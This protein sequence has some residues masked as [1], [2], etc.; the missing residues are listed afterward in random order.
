MQLQIK[1]GYL[2]LYYC[3]DISDGILLDKI[4]TV[5]GTTPEKTSLRYTRLTPAYLQYRQPPLHI[6]FG[7]QRFE[8]TDVECAVKLYD[9]G[10]ITVRISF[11]LINLSSDALIQLSKKTVENAKIE[12]FARGYMNKVKESIHHTLVP[13]PFPMEDA[14]QDYA[15]F[16]VHEF[17]KPIKGEELLKK[18]KD[19]LV[20]VLKS[21]K[22]ILSTD[23][24]TDSLKHYI[25]YY[26]HDITIVDWNAAFLYDPQQGYDV[27]DI[28]E[29]GVIELLE[30][31]A[32]DAFLDRVLDKAYEDLN[33]RHVSNSMLRTLSQV[34]L[35]VADVIEKV[36]NSLKLVGDLYLAKIYNVTATRF[37]LDRWKKS[38]RQKLGTLEHLYKTLYDRKQNAR[39]MFLEILIALFF[40]IDLVLLFFQTF[41]H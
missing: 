30:L 15:V 19:F 39:M 38:V 16:F 11:P 40:I 1:K 28:L 37:Y 36:E 10:V 17:N 7:T 29:Y 24:K 13:H 14:W 25:T 21:E 35:D 34:R 9:F 2:S 6:N 22:S 26:E 20:Q 27:L 23:E 41:H 33:R 32:Y 12:Q 4:E 8:N 3:Y 5:V 31:R 18:H